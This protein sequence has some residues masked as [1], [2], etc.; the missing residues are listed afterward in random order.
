M[1]NRHRHGSSSNSPSKEVEKTKTTLRYRGDNKVEVAHVAHHKG[2]HD[3]HQ[4]RE[5]RYHFDHKVS[6]ASYKDQHFCERE[7]YEAAGLSSAAAAAE[8]KVVEK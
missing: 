1:Q 8:S 5:Q 2:E 6:Q 3:C 4:K 7:T